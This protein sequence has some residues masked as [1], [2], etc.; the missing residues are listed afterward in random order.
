MVENPLVTH[1]NSEEW[2]IEFLR[3][4][5]N[6]G[7]R[8][9]FKPSIKRLVI[10]LKKGCYKPYPSSPPMGLCS[11]LISEGITE[12]LKIKTKEDWEQIKK[13]HNL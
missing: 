8:I 11:S 12:T 10:N 9:Y 1:I 2:C 13:E 5:K 7:G 4:V 6:Q 3:N